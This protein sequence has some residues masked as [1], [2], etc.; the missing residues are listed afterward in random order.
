MQINPLLPHN[1]NK[2]SC[3]PEESL[4]SAVLPH[5]S[6]FL[7]STN[8]CSSFPA[9]SPLHPTICKL[10]APIFN[11]LPFIRTEG[12]CHS[13]SLNQWN[14]SH[15][16]LSCGCHIRTKGTDFSPSD[17]KGQSSLPVLVK[18]QERDRVKKRGVKG[19]WTHVDPVLPPHPEFCEKV[20]SF[21]RY[22]AP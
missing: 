13:F 17:E 11:F 4:L 10:S 19:F 1:N 22:S 5:T 14:Y 2:K 16:S 15:V 21:L 3:M 7:L 9:G 20:P 6:N 12:V 18:K 8:S